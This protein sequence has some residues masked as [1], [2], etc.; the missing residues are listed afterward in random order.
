MNCLKWL[1]EKANE[2]LQSA[3][4]AYDAG[5]LEGMSVYFLTQ[6]PSVNFLQTLMLWVEA[7]ESILLF[8]FYSPP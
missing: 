6:K 8:F 3:L 2:I 7:V 4:E 5:T 1:E